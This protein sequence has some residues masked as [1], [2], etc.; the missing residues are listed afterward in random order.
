MVAKGME[1]EEMETGKKSREAEEGKGREMRTRKFVV[2][3]LFSNQP[4][5]TR[6][7][8]L[9]RTTQLHSQTQEW[10]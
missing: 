10:K 9:Y 3:A 5:L 8:K 1:M 2:I 4:S 7:I 6:V